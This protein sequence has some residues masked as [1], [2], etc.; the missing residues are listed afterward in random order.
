MAVADMDFSE[1]CA[2]N[3]PRFRIDPE[4]DSEWFFGNQQVN[5]DLLQRIRNDFDIRGVPKFGIVGRFGAGKTHTLYHFKYLFDRQ[6]QDY[7]AV[8]FY[9]RVAP[10]DEGIGDLNGWKY[11]HAKML[12]SV[13]EQ[14]L[15]EIVRDFD[16]LPANRTANLAEQMVQVFRFGDDNLRRSLANVL[17]GHFLRDTESTIPAWQWLKGSK[18]GRSAEGLGTT[19]ALETAEDMVHM[20][21][22]IGNLVRNTRGKGIVFLMDEAQAF[23][24]VEKRHIEIHDVLLQLASDD[25]EDV[26]FVIAYFGAGQQSIPK[27]LRQPDDILSRLGVTLQNT[28]A[29]FIDLQ[30][31]INTRDDV[32][33]FIDKLL[34]GVR[35]SQRAADLI[36]DQGLSGTLAPEQLPFTND[37]IERIVEVVFHN[38]QTRNARM[39]INVIASVA[40]AA[41]QKAKADGAYV[42]AD[43]DFVEPELKGL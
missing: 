16:Q 40:A 11:L 3:R 4:E 41:Y 38:E 33:D 31:L 15:R 26:G 39:I 32:R 20:V 34:A 23:N 19:K 43:R 22:N 29:A 18:L 2:L 1:Y 6:P 14:F 25:N 5:G 37:A 35:D 13:G 36:S 24:E 42:V 7:P 12:D 8:C 17:S 28:D 9:M 30:R 10:Y 21:L 27:V